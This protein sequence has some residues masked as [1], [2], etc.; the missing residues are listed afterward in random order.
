MT[1]RFLERKKC[2]IIDELKD[3]ATDPIFVAAFA[4]KGSLWN[5]EIFEI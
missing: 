3:W 4:E 2:C 5:K 1:R